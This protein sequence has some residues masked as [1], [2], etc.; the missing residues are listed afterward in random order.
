MTALIPYLLK[1]FLC[2]SLMM[3]YYYLAL[4]NKLF[5]QWNRFYLIATVI[6]SFLIPCFSFTISHTPEEAQSHVIQVLKVVTVSGPY[7]EELPTIP[8]SFLEAYG[9]ILVYTTIS[10]ILFFSLVLSLFNIYK[11]ANQHGV[12]QHGAM[13]LVLTAAKGT[14]F[15][16]F[17]LLFWNP[18]IDMNTDAGQ[19][20]LKHELVHIE[21]KH[22]LD[23]FFIQ[24]VLI[25]A[26]MN[27]VFWLIRYELRMVHEFI[28]DRKAVQDQDA[29]ALAAMILQA[30][31]PQH[32]SQL[33]NAFFHRSIKRRLQM[34]TKIQNPKRNYISR[35]LFLPLM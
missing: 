29:S 32:F 26:W 27:P 8:V 16:F 13:R 10:T 23:K 17:N 7:E 30:A 25:I 5:H 24:L 11:L 21:E 2:S 14:P 28:A 3:G 4:R 33:T 31:Y 9:L 15:S 1:V 20:V 6:L 18:S 12:Q 19:Q 34:L 22:S 35:I